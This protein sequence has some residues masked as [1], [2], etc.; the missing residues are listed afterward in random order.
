[1]AEE[2]GNLCWYKTGINGNELVRFSV[3]NTGAGHYTYTGIFEEADQD[4][5]NSS[6]RYAIIGEVELDGNSYVGSFSG[7]K[8]TDTFFKT[9]IARVTLNPRDMSGVVERIRHKVDKSSGAITSNYKTTTL[10][11]VQCP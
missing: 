8:S 3:T 4:G 11:N 10:V 1:M 5:D 2:I 7:S 6:I 9:F